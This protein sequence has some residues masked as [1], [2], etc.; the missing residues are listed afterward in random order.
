MLV[1]AREMALESGGG[2]AG[3]VAAAPIAR[4]VIVVVEVEIGEGM[5][6]AAAG[7]N[8]EFAVI[9]RLGRVLKQE[10]R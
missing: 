3:V 9:G 1:V 2:K 5:E 6:F 8:L 7:A 4:V 10:K